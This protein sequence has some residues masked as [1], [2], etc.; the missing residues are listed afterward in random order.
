MVKGRSRV[1]IV[2]PHNAAL[3]GV[4]E[5]AVKLLVEL[6]WAQKLVYRD[7]VG[8][9]VFVSPLGKPNDVYAFHKDD[10][11]EWGS[12]D[13]KVGQVV[14]VTL[15]ENDFEG[16]G[17]VNAMRDAIGLPDSKVMLTAVQDDI[18][19]VDIEGQ[20]Y[21]L[22]KKWVSYVPGGMPAEAQEVKKENHEERLEKALQKVR[23]AYREDWPDSF[24]EDEISS[25]AI[26][27]KNYSYR[28]FFRDVCHAS[29]KSFEG[30][31]AVIDFIDLHLAREQDVYESE[32]TY[33][34]DFLEYVDYWINR[35]PFADVC[36][37]KNVMD[38]VKNGILY[39]TK[40]SVHAIAQAA[41]GLRMFTEKPGRLMLWIELKKNMSEDLARII[42][43][44]ASYDED[45]GWALHCTGYHDLIGPYT[46]YKK[47]LHN[48]K[49]RKLPSLLDPEGFGKSSRRY[50]IWDN[51][52][53][54]VVEGE[55]S[56]GTVIKNVGQR[57]DIDAF[58][59]GIIKDT[60]FI[61][62]YEN[63]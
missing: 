36:I 1:I 22:S 33:H 54:Q 3:M 46:S 39:N 11:K 35:S 21:W 60:P 59:I 29:L 16:P 20:I 13:Y 51:M 41:I 44:A 27:D 37:T 4:G 52:A 23:E 30:D 31:R 8:A 14:Y 9:G 45:E 10:I 43:E 40:Y 5:D 17:V 28:K 57:Q 55:D 47:V 56:F 7:S 25:F 48:W 26:I 32:A 2:R 18:V 42:A 6:G 50:H 53:E 24:D 12:M 63:A 38:A 58:V 49:H 61:K 15:P 62:D 34:K 19:G